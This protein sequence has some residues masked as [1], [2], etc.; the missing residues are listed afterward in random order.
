SF[1]WNTLHEVG[2]AVD[3]AN[4]F[5]GRFGS[6]GDYGGWRD[7]KNDVSE[8]AAEISKQYKFDRGYAARYLGG[9][10]EPEI[11]PPT[12]GVDAGEWENRRLQVRRHIDEARVGNQ[13]WQAAGRAQRLKLDSGRVYHE[14]YP[15]HWVSYELNARKQAITGYQWRAPGEWFSELYAAYRSDKLKN[16]SHPAVKWLSDL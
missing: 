4:N 11:P 7:H 8:V 14:A 6:G 10:K 12:D 13:P 16:E 9:T 1:T 15:N 5:M 3:D 2:H